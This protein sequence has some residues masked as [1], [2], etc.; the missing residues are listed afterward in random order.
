MF[1][2]W[3]SQQ[4]PL[5]VKNEKGCSSDKPSSLIPNF[6]PHLWGPL[7]S[8]AAPSPNPTCKLSLL[9][10]ATFLHRDEQCWNVSCELVSTVEQDDF[11]AWG[12]PWRSPENRP[13]NR[14]A[15]GKEEMGEKCTLFK[16]K[17]WMFLYRQIRQE[18]GRYQMLKKSWFWIYR[19]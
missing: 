1:C 14:I 9:Y 6:Q 11:P 8:R 2:F 7:F 10:S 13:S 3:N 4:F 17:Y 15:G 18:N 19:N 12:W 5:S 16:D